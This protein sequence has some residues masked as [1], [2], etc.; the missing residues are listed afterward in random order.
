MSG[1][2]RRIVLRLKSS[3]HNHRR[4]ALPRRSLLSKAVMDV[5]HSAPCQL[6]NAGHSA[7][8]MTLKKKEVVFPTSG[9]TAVTA[10][11]HA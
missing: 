8:M 10:E 1:R 3:I 9:M 11:A 5:M 2:E 4:L 7:H 6:Q